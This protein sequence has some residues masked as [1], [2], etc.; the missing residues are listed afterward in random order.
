[1][2]AA[3]K[4][5]TP[6][7]DWLKLIQDHILAKPDKVP[8]GWKTVAQIA[9]ETGKGEDRAR[10]IVCNLR[11]QGLVE[12]RKFTVLHETGTFRIPHYRIKPSKS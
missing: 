1:M 4:L 11:K 12:V 10:K 5:H 7:K 9:K 8:K 2:G 6:M 3:L